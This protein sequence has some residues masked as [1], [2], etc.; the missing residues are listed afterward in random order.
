MKLQMFLL[1][2]LTAGIGV[3]GAPLKL[4]MNYY[5]KYNGGDFDP[6]FRRVHFPFPVLEMSSRKVEV[7]KRVS[8][9]PNRVELQYPCGAK[10]SVEIGDS[11]KVRLRVWNI[12]RGVSRL[13]QTATLPYEA[14]TGGTAVLGPCRVRL[15]EK[16]NGTLCFSH[17]QNS[18]GIYPAKGEG[19]VVATDGV[20][21][22]EIRLQD[23]S[24]WNWK[25]F[26][27]FLC[28]EIRSAFD[29]ALIVNL[30]LN[31]GSLPP[32][33][34]A[35]REI[36]VDRFGQSTR[37]DWPGKVKQESDFV[38]L[39]NEEEKYYASLPPVPEQ[40]RFG[41]LAGSREKYGLKATGFFRTDKVAGRDVL[42]TPD[43]NLF[44]ML[45]AAGLGMCDSITKVEGREDSFEWLPKRS[46]GQVFYIDGKHV[47]FYKM[48][49]LRKYGKSFSDRDW[50]RMFWKRLR[51]WGFNSFGPFNSIPVQDYPPQAPYAVELTPPEKLNLVR[52]IFDPYD[53][54]R[55]DQIE[56]FLRKKL[57]QHSANPWCIGYYLN[58]E[59]PF[60]EIIFQIPK[61]G[62]EVAAK[63]ALCR[64]LEKRYRSIEA[65]N[66]GWKTQFRSFREL[67]G[68]ALAVGPGE[69]R[70]AMEGF[71]EEFLERYFSV[72]TRLV[73]KYDS[74]HLL[75][76]SRIMPHTA[77]PRLLR[78]MG[79]YT[80]VLSVNYY[81]HGVDL[82]YLRQISQNAGG[83][84]IILSE[85][86]FGEK[87]HGHSGGVRNTADQQERGL[88]YRN[89]LEQSAALP[90]VVGSVF[91]Q[92]VDQPVSGRWIGGFSGERFNC[93]LIDV[94]DQPYRDFLREVRLS[95][96]EIYDVILNRRPPYRLEKAPYNLIGRKQG[97]REFAVSRIVS[98]VKVDGT[99][100]GWPQ[101]PAQ[102]I[103]ASDLVFGT[104]AVNIRADFRACFD[105]RNIYFD[106]KVTDP[107][108]LRNRQSGHRIWLGDCIELFFAT[109]RP[110][111][112]G[113]CLPGDRQLVIACRPGK[114]IE[115]HWYNNAEQLE[116]V[117]IPI[118]IGELPGTGYEVQFAIPLAALGLKPETGT[119]FRFDIGFGDSE[120]GRSRARQFM[121]SGSDRNARDR[122][123]YGRATLIN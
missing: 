108:P 1:A 114:E 47:S 20:D 18:I 12:P 101:L 48:N 2:V 38:R 117:K 70:Q 105:D 42:V 61:K 32:P 69:S 59:Q 88:A 34:A 100:A 50:A 102:Q 116:P 106:V 83:K 10:A 41:G 76:G 54:E 58:N 84:P 109:V 52:L 24:V 63:R 77:A 122:S 30:S 39:R 78:I 31:S 103:T 60:D 14:F 21:G 71:F 123:G 49:L 23:N 107:T 22:S 115:Y 46:D 7:P 89:Y 57:A 28:F 97:T 29:N 82:D 17:N 118:R 80:D 94:T 104:G 112:N 37:A 9:T 6:G 98:P 95:N 72:L 15:G 111:Q 79:R 67:E 13:R 64:Y 35:K 62:A 5:D 19:L 3:S 90:F 68:A 56:E 44:F 86:S 93:G 40:G 51:K 91:F 85:W 74:N 55:I 120:D 8:Q 27:L 119:E 121:W 99:L 36:L 113:E 26:E 73:R 81:T 43:G 65:F 16:N 75:L 11:G 66:R 45:A 92:C 33:E 110:E 53:Q 87:S 25:V 4:K 96:A